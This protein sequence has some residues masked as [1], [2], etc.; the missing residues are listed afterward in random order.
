MDGDLRA[1]SAPRDGN[2]R[3]AEP[4]ARAP[5]HGIERFVHLPL[6]SDLTTGDVEQVADRRL[7][8]LPVEPSLE[9]ERCGR[10]E[11]AGAIPTSDAI[12][13]ISA[14][15]NRPSGSVVSPS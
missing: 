14:S 5:F 15:E 9:P 10:A 7:R 13:W 6:Q 8:Y 2:D 11:R 1:P 3:A 4:T 12:C